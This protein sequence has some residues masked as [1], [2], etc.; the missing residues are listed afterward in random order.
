MHAPC[1]PPSSSTSSMGALRALLAQGADRLPLPGSG[2]TLARWQALAS[3]AARDVP[4]AKL[5]EGHTDAHAILAELQAPGAP[6]AWATWCAEPP[7][8]RL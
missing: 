5:W 3:V 2:R 1:A 7:E 6:G 8:A 4:L